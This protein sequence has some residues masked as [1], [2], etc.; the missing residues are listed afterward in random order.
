MK[1]YILIIS[2]LFIFACSEPPKST[3][4]ASEDKKEEFVP[5]PN[6]FTAKGPDST[7]ADTSS[8]VRRA[9]KPGMMPPKLEFEQKEYILDSTPTDGIL[10]KIE[11]TN[12]GDKPLELKSLR[13]SK[14]ADLQWSPLLLSSGEKSSIGYRLKTIKNTTSFRDT[15]FVMSNAGEDFVVVWGK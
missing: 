3:E 11:F 5:P 12:I 7:K 4:I 15:V 1:H 10:L 2:G 9:E 8:P 6:P 13:S 14:N